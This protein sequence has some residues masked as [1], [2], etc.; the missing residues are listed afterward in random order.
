M[1]KT[2]FLA[3]IF[4]LAIVFYKFYISDNESRLRINLPQTPASNI[5]DENTTQK[6]VL[7]ENLEVP[8]ALA[9]L[10]TGEIMV[11]ER[12]G[13]VRLL[14]KDGKLSSTPLL[15]LEVVK[16]IQGEGGLHGIAI[17][18]DFGKNRFVYLYYTYANQGESSLNRVVRYTLKENALIQDVIIVDKIPGALFHDGGRIKF[19]PD[20]NLYI[21]TGDAQ[22][23][24]LS[25]DRNSLAGKILRVTDDGNP[26]A[27]NPF[28]NLAYSYGHRNPQ[29]IAWDK[30][31]ILWETE[32]GQSA[33]DEV[34]RIEQ[35]KNYGWPEIRGNQERS[36]M[37]KPRLHSGSDTWAPSD[38]A[39][40]EDR[41]F[42]GGLR[43][44]A[45][46]ELDINSLN[47]KTHFKGELGRIREVVLGP[48][49]MLYIT[50]SN[51]DGRGSVRFGDDKIIRI[52]P[53]SL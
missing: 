34:N 19:G 47:L 21:S 31:G 52:N 5:N 22:N 18:P 2:V 25:Q 6:V 17:H 35:G 43:G 33:T 48:D 41:L 20:K 51:R 39:F 4:I 16:R 23:P 9:F 38:M 30:N 10:P 1:R 50:T 37:E 24:S 49:N 11:T 8:W 40:V 14:G 27:G 15:E 53:E 28:G 36:G 3:V 42:F 46:F 29:G 12:P 32:H 44:E 45:L 26:V 13:R 7:A